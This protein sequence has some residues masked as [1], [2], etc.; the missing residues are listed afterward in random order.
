MES[1]RPTARSVGPAPRSGLG[2][3]WAIAAAA[4]LPLG[5]VLGAGALSAARD[6]PGVGLPCTV[7]PS[8]RVLAQGGACPL[9]AGG[10]LLAARAG[11]VPIEP[12]P[13]ALR[14][15]AREHPETPIE[16]RIRTA[17]G[18]HRLALNPEHRDRRARWV[19]LLRFVPVGA[20]LL[21]LP[22]L[23]LRTGAP[24]A[25]PLALLYGSVAGLLGAAVIGRWL[26]EL[27]AIGVVGASLAPAALLHLPLTLPRV[28]PVLAQVPAIAGAP[29][30]V[31]ALLLPLGAVAVVSDA[32]LWPV[33]TRLAGLIAA[34]GWVAL[35][36][37]CLFALRES[38]SGLERARARLVAL[39]AL[40][41][42]ALATPLLAGR[43]P[44]GVPLPLVPLAAVLA[45]LPVPLGLAIGRYDL[46]GVDRQLRLWIG[47]LALA[48]A[49]AMAVVALLVGAAELSR[50]GGAASLPP[51]FALV[52]VVLVA[53]ELF[54]PRLL[55]AVGSLTARRVPA[56]EVER[57]GLE[58]A[59][60]E[61]RDEEAVLEELAA[62]LLR[63]LRSGFVAVAVASGRGLHPVGSWPP[64]QVR[65][66]DAA[67]LAAAARLA[68]PGVALLDRELRDR[69][70]DRRRLAAFGAAAVAALRDRAEL[71]GIAVVGEPEDAEPLGSAEL[72]FLASAARHAGLALRN[73]RLARELAVA[74][75]SAATAA[76]ALALAHDLG[77]QLA[78]AEGLVRRLPARIEERSP[79]LHGDLELLRELLGELRH[80]LRG[81]LEGASGPSETGGVR[82]DEI[83]ARAVAAVR[84]LHPK[85]P[86][87]VE[88]E[89][90]A[91]AWRGGR[92]LERVVQNLVENAVL[93]SP[94]G[95][96]VRVVGVPSG[97]GVELRVVDR[98]PGPPAGG[99]ARAFE[100]GWSSRSGAAGRGIGLPV[101]REL[102]RSL[103]ATL[104]LGPAHGGG[105]V[106]T[107]G[108]RGPGGGG[109]T[110]GAAT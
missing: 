7:L 87:S 76:L 74:E 45:V 12:S 54:R 3:R 22:L 84:R 19:D 4:C 37:S 30:L 86:I 16:L 25:V 42:P 50:A 75:R 85:P 34:A 38:R 71:L 66:L 33:F 41:L 67:T 46:F 36:V 99:Y 17:S 2:A 47:R 61:L 69:D 97:A 103:G 1:A 89:P 52:F 51:A 15:A 98:G 60:A 39:G 58:R 55:G 13:Q 49:V 11:G 92:L 23:L 106:A 24:A 80:G 20:G 57:R 32:D 18:S 104:A 53:A 14:R 70:P 21:A 96:V 73:A 102:C 72:D 91:A 110:R 5:M 68:R 77:K 109:S 8:G 28:R 79:R 108:L 107:I 9:P 101:C 94:P 81:L 93:A 82:L 27:W 29:Y 31:T 100:L 48:V 83:V 44:P 78:W 62:S 26:P 56:L 10:V 59:L 65:A 105:T 43:V 40:V 35:V 88:L 90:R 6:G 95:E 63:A 64:G